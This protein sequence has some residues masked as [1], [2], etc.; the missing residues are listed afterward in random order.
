MQWTDIDLSIYLI[1]LKGKAGVESRKQE[2]GT[3]TGKILRVKLSPPVDDAQPP[4]EQRTTVDLALDQWSCLQGPFVSGASQFYF[5]YFYFSFFKGHSIS[6]S[7]W[8]SP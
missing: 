8:K 1:Y 7:C 3:T 5:L 2:D 4:P 6:L